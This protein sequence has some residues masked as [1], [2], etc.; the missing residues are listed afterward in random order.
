[1]GPHDS[2][3]DPG[4]RM[5][6]A[7]HTGSM[8]NNIIPVT[9][10]IAASALAVAGWMYLR[11]T[12]RQESPEAV[13][14]P[15][16][17]LEPPDAP[18]PLPRAPEPVVVPAD[19]VPTAASPTGKISA[20]APAQ[21]ANAAAF[22]PAPAMK[23][24]APLRAPMAR[25]AMSFVGADPDAE[26]LWLEAIFDPSLPAKEREDLIED[27]NEVG[28]TDSKR[29]GPEDYLLIV[30]RLALIEKIMPDA[31]KFMLPH[32]REARKDL[33]NLA[34]LMEGEGKPVR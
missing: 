19:E 18:P 1:M 22:A 28:L 17:A 34:A 23:P 27:L 29:P 4:F 6:Y 5:Q 11:Q 8:K 10:C 14:S 21:S 15:T 13:A 16:H 26:S 12:D 2:K 32:L 20:A 3:F 25:A 7:T 30:N 31:D 9:T 24:K 33:E